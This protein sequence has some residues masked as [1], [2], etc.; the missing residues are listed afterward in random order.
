MFDKISKAMVKVFGSRNERLIK[1]YMTT[2]LKAVEVSQGSPDLAYAETVL[3]FV[4]LTRIEVDEATEDLKFGLETVSCIGCCGQS[5]VISV[6]DEIYGY[7]KPDM[8]DDLL[9]KIQ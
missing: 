6:N 2:A 9:H 7:F 4:R 3:G 8:L 1:T 5:P